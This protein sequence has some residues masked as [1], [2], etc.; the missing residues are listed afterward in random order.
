[1]SSRTTAVGE[2][3]LEFSFVNPIDVGADLYVW[4]CYVVCMLCACVVRYVHKISR[5]IVN[6]GSGLFRMLGVT[7]ESC[8]LH[9]SGGQRSGRDP[10]KG[11]GDLE[12]P[13]SN[14]KAT[15]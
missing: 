7:H 1:M 11:K 6:E 9:P 2:E 3:G 4:R 12:I 8:D 10:N 14:E 13:E 5:P 15:P